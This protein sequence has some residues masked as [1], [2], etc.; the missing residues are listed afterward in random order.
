[1]KTNTLIC[2]DT[3]YHLDA[4]YRAGAIAM[5]QR[6]PYSV[7]N[8]HR[9]DTQQHDQFDYGHVNESAGEHVRFGVDVIKAQQNG[10]CFEEDSSVPRDEY[11]VDSDWYNNQLVVFATNPRGMAIAA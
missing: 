1:M 10:R 11:G 8:P 5:R 7:A 2:G 6:I 4:A 3:M 9:A